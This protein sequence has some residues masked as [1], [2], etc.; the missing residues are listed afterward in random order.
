MLL[1]NVSVAEKIL[2]HFSSCS[3]LRRHQVPAP[4]Q[5]EPLLKAAA[6]AGITLDVDNSKV[7]TAVTEPSFCCAPVIE[8]IKNCVWIFIHIS[9]WALLWVVERAVVVE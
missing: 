4:R 3:L 6:A 7:V 8:N 5:F 9:V 2:A 1:A